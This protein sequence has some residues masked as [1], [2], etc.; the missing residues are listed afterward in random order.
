M[1]YLIDA[2]TNASSKPF[3][4]FV[5][6]RDTSDFRIKEL[7]GTCTSST[8][9]FSIS[10]KDNVYHSQAGINGEKVISNFPKP[11]TEITFIGTHTNATY[12]YAV[13][14]ISTDGYLVEYGNTNADNTDMQDW[15]AVGDVVISDI[16]YTLA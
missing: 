12:P 13:F 11:A 8:C 4:P 6:N 3:I 7:S 16:T 9:N 10:F 14:K 15:F 5:Y 1:I 2:I